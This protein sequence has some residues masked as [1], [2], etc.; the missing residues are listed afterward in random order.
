MQITL[1]ET[2]AQYGRIL[3]DRLFPRMEEELGPLPE[4]HQQTVKVLGL[5][6]IDRWIPSRRG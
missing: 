5:L 6:E 4:K 3:Q 2:L 1:L